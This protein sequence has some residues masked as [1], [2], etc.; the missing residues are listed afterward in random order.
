[1][2]NINMLKVIMIKIIFVKN[3][4]VYNIGSDEEFSI[5]DVFKLLIA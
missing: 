2:K 1:M 3:W 5:I 4:E